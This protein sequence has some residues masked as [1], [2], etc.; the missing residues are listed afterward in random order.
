[1]VYSGLLL[2]PPCINDVLSTVI[3]LNY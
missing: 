2:G 1:L 3:S